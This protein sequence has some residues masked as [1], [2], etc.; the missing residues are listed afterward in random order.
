M[1]QL[2]SVSTSWRVFNQLDDAQL[3]HFK[4]AG[5]EALHAQLLYNRGIKSPA[6]MRMFLDADYDSTPDPLTLI[7][8]PRALERIQHALARQERITVHG[9]YDADGV[10]SAALL[11]RAL[12]TLGHPGHLLD[13][14][15]PNRLRESRGLNISALDSLKS[16]GTSLLITRTGS[17][18]EHPGHRCH[19]H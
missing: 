5:I 11:I 6:A 19:H 15:I 4:Q 2:P 13:Y 18:R 7:D 8:V 1:G 3:Q 9:D 10:T 12:R 16:K 14:Y 17:I